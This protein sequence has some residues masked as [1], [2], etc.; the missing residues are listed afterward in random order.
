MC[1][2]SEGWEEAV[3]WVTGLSPLNK[4]ICFMQEIHRRHLG[5]CT[6]KASVDPTLPK[7]KE[8]KQ[9]GWGDHRV[10]RHPTTWGWTVSALVLGM[11]V[12][13]PC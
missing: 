12:L 5:P 4:F 10:C 11:E 6:E 2:V 1:H 13:S 3:G 9:R 8:T 7:G